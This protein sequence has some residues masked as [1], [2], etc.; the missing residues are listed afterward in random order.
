MTHNDNPRN[1]SMPSDA[2]YVF[3]A[4]VNSRERLI[5]PYNG[6]D[7]FTGWSLGMAPQQIPVSVIAFS[8]VAGEVAQLKVVSEAVKGEY[9]KLKGSVALLSAEVRLTETMLADVTPGVTL[10]VF[11]LPPYKADIFVHKA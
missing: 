4:L 11:F 1:P 10:V 5:A 6:R 9:T 7:G 3:Y 8:A 2:A